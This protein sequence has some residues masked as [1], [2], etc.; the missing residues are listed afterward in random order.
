MITKVCGMR[1]ADNIREVEA[2]GIDWMGFIFW[3]PS[4][5]YCAEKPEY[6][7]KKCKRVGVFVNADVNEI[8]EKVLEYKL[9][10]VQLHG[11]EDRAYIIKL[12]K[13]IAETLEDVAKEDSE[14]SY[15]KI[16]LIIKALS[17]SKKE[18]LQ[19]TNDYIGFVD[20][21]LFDT[22]SSTYGGTGKSFDWSLLE[23]YC[24]F[25]PFLLSGGIGLDS[26]PALNAFHNPF[27]VG[28]DLNSR[29]ESV[30]GVKD[31]EKLKSFVEGISK[32]K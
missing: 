31:I 17:L 9:D 29:F 4:K 25:T 6:L 10:L 32:Q 15:S 20:Y 23:N 7:P 12:R 30:P 26:I 24:Q 19:K 28:Y 11:K 3:K 18:D 22:P 13:A 21:F 5:R 1:S 14:E 2:L 27:C 8:V 16:P